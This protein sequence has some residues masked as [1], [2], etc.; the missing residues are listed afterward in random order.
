M[1]RTSRLRIFVPLKTLPRPD[2]NAGDRR[3]C[4]LIEIMAR[5]HRVDLWPADQQRQDPAES[6]RYHSLLTAAGVN[7]LACDWSSYV[8]AM[9]AARYHIGLF[10]F[11]Q[12]AE[13]F[14]A[15]F[16][17]RQPGAVVVVDSVDVHFARL[18]AGVELG[19]TDSTVAR[20]VES[21][22]LAAYRA[23]DAVIAVSDAEAT[24]LQTA[25]GIRQL[26]VVP[27]IIP[28]RERNEAPRKGELLFVGG[29]RHAPNVDGILWFMDQVWPLVTAVAA[30]T[31][32]TIVGSHPPP[33]ILALSRVR[34]VTVQGFVPDVGPLL[35]RAAISIAPL[36]Y[37]GGMKGK[38]VEALAS[39]VPVVTTSAGVQGLPVRIGTD[40]LASDDA[41]GFAEDVLSLLCDPARAREVGAAG[42]RAAA[43]CA[44]EQVERNIDHMMRALVPHPHA[45]RSRVTWLRSAAKHALGNVRR[46]AVSG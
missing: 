35:D 26:Y 4:A 40:L 37:G 3:F 17:Q 32:L 28:Q 2:E 16:R 29:F 36:R 18:A 42:Q 21:R 8:W 43:F 11:H 30:D 7:V 45:L 15:D 24:L 20:A 46:R 34:G 1:P 31:T 9:T 12:T 33:E 41:K 19:L 44:P 39:G 5:H 22:E 27:L 38:V 13:R 10:E 14:A 23:A 6:R 25:G